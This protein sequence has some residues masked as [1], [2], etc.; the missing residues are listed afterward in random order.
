MDKG[1]P[2]CNAV[3][4]LMHNAAH[5]PG[6]TS[7]AAILS[8]S[9]RTPLDPQSP[10]TMPYAER[11]EVLIEDLRIQAL[12]GVNPGEFGQPQLLIVNIRLEIAPCQR[13]DLRDTVDYRQIAAKAESLASRHLGL[14]E[15]FAAQLVHWCLQFDM[16]AMAEVVIGK[17]G[18]MTNGLAKTRV[19]ISKGHKDSRT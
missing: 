10:P 7:D 16:V 9:A 13:D 15:T 3:G 8:P 1:G 18:A 6:G 5:Q 14:I 17:P 11:Y 19:S 12:I 4:S 2:P